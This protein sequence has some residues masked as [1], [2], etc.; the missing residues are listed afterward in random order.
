[1]T[2]FEQQPPE[3]Q[4]RRHLSSGHTSETEAGLGIGGNRGEVNPDQPG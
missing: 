2:S 4:S 3:Q 1:V